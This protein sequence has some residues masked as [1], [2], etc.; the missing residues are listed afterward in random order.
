MLLISRTITFKA[1]TA[2]EWSPRGRGNNSS[3]G[4]GKDI[5]DECSPIERGNNN[6]SGNGRGRADDS[7]DKHF[8]AVLKKT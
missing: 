4:N 6:T 2:N 7:K 5:P 1:S 8:H 3:S